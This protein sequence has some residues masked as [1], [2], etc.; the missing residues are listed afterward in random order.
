LTKVVN[1][2]K[3]RYSIHKNLTPHRDETLFQNSFIIIRNSDSFYCFSYAELTLLKFIR[4]EHAGDAGIVYC[5][6]RKKV[7]ETSVWLTKNSISATPYHAGMDTQTRIEHQEKFLREED[8][9]TV[10][11]TAFGLGIDKPDV[12]FVAHLDLPKSAESYYQETSRAGRGGRT[13]NA[14]MFDGSGDVM[15]LDGTL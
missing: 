5:Q 8:I 15:Q 6:S 12:R 11:T 1:R 3:N 2:T 14:W 4:T 9:V 10:A 13:A 7:E